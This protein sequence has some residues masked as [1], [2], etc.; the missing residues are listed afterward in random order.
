M[1]IPKSTPYGYVR[2]AAWLNIFVDIKDG[3]V[4]C[5]LCS[6]AAGVIDPK[7]NSKVL[8]PTEFLHRPRRIPDF[9]HSLDL[10]VLVHG[11]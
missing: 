10:V 2:D 5:A 3:N 1:K 7:E 9:R 6:S 8:Y 4:D 11:Q